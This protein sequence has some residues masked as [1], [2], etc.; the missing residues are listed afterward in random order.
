MVICGVK[1]QCTCD[2]L[3]FSGCILPQFGESQGK[4]KGR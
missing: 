1:V 2:D 3:Q 4:D